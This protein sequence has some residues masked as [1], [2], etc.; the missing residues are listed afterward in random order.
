MILVDHP[1]LPGLLLLPPDTPPPH[2]SHPSHQ[3]RLCRGP[4]HSAYRSQMLTCAIADSTWSVAVFIRQWV[5][6][7]SVT[8]RIIIFTR[9]FM[10]D[11]TRRGNGVEIRR[12][13]ASRAQDR[14]SANQAHPSA[15]VR[16]VPL[17]SRDVQSTSINAATSGE[18]QIGASQ[19]KQ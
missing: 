14:A 5:E 4:V 13:G 12:S 15:A 1:V 3:S 6:D 7:A 18:H 17:L 11:S 2:K 19:H 8:E 16:F 10:T 9:S